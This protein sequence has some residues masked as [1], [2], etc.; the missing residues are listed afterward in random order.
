MRT[1]APVSYFV[2]CPQGLI[3][4]CYVLNV[5]DVM[6]TQLGV[7]R[8]V[9]LIHVLVD[10]VYSLLTSGTFFYSLLQVPGG[11]RRAGFYGALKY[12]SL[13][14]DHVGWY[15]FFLFVYFLESKG[16]PLHYY[17]KPDG[18]AQVFVELIRYQ[19]LEQQIH[20]L[21]TWSKSYYVYCRIII[22]RKY[23]TATFPHQAT[24]LS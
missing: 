7:F 9:H 5:S 19:H 3:S 21:A 17:F 18:L 13:I 22:N 14:L 23:Q 6:S 15:S 16:L 8:V 2:S 12:G 4:C 20:F 1:A 24:R 11:N 10:V